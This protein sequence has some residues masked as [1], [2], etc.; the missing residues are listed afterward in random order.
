MSHTF[1]EEVTKVSNL[2]QKRRNFY[3]SVGKRILDIIAVLAAIPII[4]PVVLITWSAAYFSGGHGFYGQNRVG[5]HGRIFRCWKIRTMAIESD[6]ILS[7]L[8]QSNPDAAREWQKSQKLQ[9]D[10]RITRFGHF[11]RASSI[12]ELPQIWNILMG[13]MSLIGP[14]PFTVNQKCLYDA[15]SPRK[16]YYDLRPGLSG[17]WQVY[18]RNDGEFSDRVS[19]DEEYADNISLVYDVKIALRTIGVVLRATGK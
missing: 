2:V 18:S 10:P 8:L 11:L 13:D 7:E 6:N 16:S 14:R 15:S 1:F 19:S 9:N 5:R 17:L 3:V 12:D 4:L